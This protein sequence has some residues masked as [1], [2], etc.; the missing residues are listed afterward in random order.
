MAAWLKLK[1]IAIAI[2]RSFINWTA[3]AARAIS[4]KFGGRRWAK[5]PLSSSWTSFMGLPSSTWFLLD[6]TRNFN[7]FS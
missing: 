1:K 5:T 2:R 7:E 4:S 6:K 3:S